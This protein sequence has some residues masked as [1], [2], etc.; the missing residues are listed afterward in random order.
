M[1]AAS[2]GGASPEAAADRGGTWVTAR[3]GSGSYRTEITA[4]GH[5]LV[6]DES[7]TVGG[8]GGGAS[9]YELLLSAIGSCTAMTMRMYAS[10]KQWPLEE[11]TVRLRNGRRYAEDCENCEK[12][13]VGIQQIERQIDMKGDL[14][15][16]QRQR[17]LLIA[18]RC[19]V[20]QTLEKGI[21]VITVP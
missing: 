3:T 21:K 8:G 20:K 9:P 12:Q 2:G 11:V 16:E 5:D 4:G 17:L 1:S 18:D 14:T 19:P 7:T 6:A 10:R 13:S 15:D